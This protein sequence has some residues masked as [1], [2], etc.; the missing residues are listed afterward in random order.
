ML[1]KSR[2]SKKP[3]ANNPAQLDGI[4]IRL[5]SFGQIEKNFD[6]EQ[7][8]SFLNENVP[9]KKKSGEEE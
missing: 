8:N 7:I 6:A 2:T 9:D 3:K 5:N 4:Q 1:K